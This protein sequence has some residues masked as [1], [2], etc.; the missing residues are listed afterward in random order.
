MRGRALGTRQ[1]TG[2]LLCHMDTPW[3]GRLQPGRPGRAGI[4]MIQEV[5]STAVP[6]LFRQG[7]LREGVGVCL[8]TTTQNQSRCIVPLLRTR[9]PGHQPQPRP[10]PPFLNGTVPPCPSYNPSHN[11]REIFF[12]RSLGLLCH[13][14]PLLVLRAIMYVLRCLLLPTRGILRAL[15]VT[16]GLWW[17]LLNMG[18]GETEEKRSQWYSD[19]LGVGGR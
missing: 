12:L 5:R 4:G 8:S 1:V 2:M 13:H 17:D 6:T 14:V 11:C 15:S 10:A 7:R 9:S 16:E 3:L 19:P 18:L